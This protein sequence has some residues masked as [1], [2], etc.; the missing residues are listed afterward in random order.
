[1][2]HLKMDR[3]DGPVARIQNRAAFEDAA[4][5]PELLRTIDGIP[6][7]LRGQR[8]VLNLN[9]WHR[10]RLFP[11]T[12]RRWVVLTRPVPPLKYLPLPPN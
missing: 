1:M 2:M 5:G 7:Q 6:F 10:T 4:V 3:Q 8:D 9:L 11:R 12:P